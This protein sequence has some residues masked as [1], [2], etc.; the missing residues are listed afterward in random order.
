MLYVICY[1]HR[2]S[3]YRW[4]H[5]GT[6]IWQT[7]KWQPADALVPNFR[8]LGQIYF[9]SQC[10]H[11]G[12]WRFCGPPIHVCQG[13]WTWITFKGYFILY[14]HYIYIYIYIY[15]Y[16]ILY[17]YILIYVLHITRLPL[18]IPLPHVEL[19]GF[20]ATIST[21]RAVSCC[22]KAQQDSW[23][24]KAAGSNPFF[25]WMGSQV[26][27]HQRHMYIYMCICVYVYVCT[28]WIL[29][30]CALTLFDVYYIHIRLI[31]SSPLP[32]SWDGCS[33]RN[34]WL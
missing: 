4:S 24:W 20:R 32:S 19:K 26:I 29:K 5:I 12:H 16:I 2:I 21:P 3:P 8:K 6:M 33:K 14:I 15:W 18:A 7:S 22:C 17:I 34:G 1:E 13:F 11:V 25:W 31:E 28:C 27:S 9:F 30:Y 10:G 23:L